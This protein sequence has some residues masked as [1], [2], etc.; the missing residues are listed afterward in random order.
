MREVKQSLQD[1]NEEHDVIKGEV[2][3]IQHKAQVN[4]DKFGEKAKEAKKYMDGLDRCHS[5]KKAATY[6]SIPVVGQ[7]CS[8]VACAAGGAEDASNHF[9]N[10]VGKVLAG[11]IGGAGGAVY[12]LGVSLVTI[13][14]GPILWCKAISHHL[15]VKNYGKLTEQFE[16]ITLQMGMVETHLEQIT[17]ALGEIEQHL[18]CAL[19]A[20]ERVML[21]VSDER[22][23]KMVKRVIESADKLIGSCDYYF[24]LIKNEILTIE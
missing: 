14:A 19:S 11:T 4:T 9:K 13:P 5:F 6:L 17:T 18:K 1:A 20:E 22:R 15:D 2:M 12:G 23:A 21:D 24:T 3:T 8:T 7:V 10:P 16:N